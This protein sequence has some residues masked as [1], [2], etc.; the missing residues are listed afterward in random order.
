MQH[1]G[2][3]VNRLIRVAYGPFQL[4]NLTK[5]ALIE[6]KQKILREQLGIEFK[7][8]NSSAHRRR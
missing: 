2:W 1:L 7:R 5:G 4:G 3:P 6:V 8:E